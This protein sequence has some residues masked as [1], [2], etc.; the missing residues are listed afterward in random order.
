MTTEPIAAPS[1]IQNYAQKEGRRFARFLV[2][3]ALGFAVDFGVF[4]LAHAF[5]VGAW[6]AAH[7]TPA[8]SLPLASYLGQHPEII[9]QTLSFTLAVISNFVWNYFWIYP[10]AR[11]A[12]QSDRIFKFIIV[13]FVGLFLGVPVF[14]LAL[15]IW[16]GVIAALRLG[17]TS[18][19]LLGNLALM[20]RVGVLLFWNFFINRY[21]TYKDVQ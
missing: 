3:G 21:W 2:V 15:Y 4:N 17:G 8:L 12:K 9:E 18:L 5:G 13:S 14:S 1:S 6:V 7:A 11:A 10:E 19:N 16:G 20:T